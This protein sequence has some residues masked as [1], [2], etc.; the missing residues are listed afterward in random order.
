MKKIITQ[1]DDG[2]RT[3]FVPEIDEHYHST[4]GAYAESQ[5]IFIDMGLNVVH[6]SPIKILEV[7]FGTGL[8][9]LLTLI[10]AEKS[11]RSIEYTGIELYPLAFEA[12]QQLDYQHLPLMTCSNSNE[13]DSE[14]QI[15]QIE[16]WIE[17]LHQS[18]WETPIVLTPSFSL[19][20]IKADLNQWLNHE[21]SEIFDLIYFDAFSPEKQPDLW[22]PELFNALYHRLNVKGVMTTYCAKGV[23]RRMLEGAGFTVERLPGPPNGKREILR[24]TRNH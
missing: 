8:N 14:R 15:K 3:I 9:A 21:T 24:A 20:K 18:C 17:G 1:T 23:V 13:A 12:V 19:Q 2:S 5:H 10:E 16:K 11:K 4:K 22:T 7:G 6:K